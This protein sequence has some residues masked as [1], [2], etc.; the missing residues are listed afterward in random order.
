MTVRHRARWEDLEYRTLFRTC[1]PEAVAPS[2]RLLAQL[3]SP[4]WGNGLPTLPNE[5]RVLAR[6][7]PA[8]ECS[9]AS[10]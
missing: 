6:R 2:I 9:T 3:S 1:P 5:R 10:P 8:Q 7:P 4:I